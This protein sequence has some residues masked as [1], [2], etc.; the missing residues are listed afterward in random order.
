M[1]LLGQVS[2]TL[3]IYITIPLFSI[4]QST[5]LFTPFISLGDISLMKHLRY[6]KV[7]TFTVD[8]P[9]GH[10]I[11]SVNAVVEDMCCANEDI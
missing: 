5:L 8:I 2:S 6:I 3:L 4:C 1:Y 11:H 7:I 9:C 10:S